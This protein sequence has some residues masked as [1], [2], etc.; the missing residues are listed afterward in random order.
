[1][2][3]RELR[4]EA[5]RPGA[6]RLRL[7]AVGMVLLICAIAA[8]PGR[9]QG[10]EVFARLQ[11]LLLTMIWMIVPVTTADCISRERREG[12]LPLLALTNLSPFAIVVAKVASRIV[13]T[14]GWFLAAIPMLLI[15]VMMGGVGA[16]EIFLA[17]VMDGSSIL[18]ALSAGM[19]A[20]VLARR[21]GTVVFLAAVIAFVLAVIF[22]MLLGGNGIPYAVGHLTS[23]WSLVLGKTSIVSVMWGSLCLT[24]FVFAGALGFCAWAVARMMNPEANAGQGRARSLIARGGSP[25]ERRSRHLQP[26]PEDAPM[27]WMF[28]QRP[29]PRN[30]KWVLM[31]SGMLMVLLAWGGGGVAGFLLLMLGLPVSL[32]FCAASSFNRERENGVLELLLVSPMSPRKLVDARLYSLMLDHL[33]LAGLLLVLLGCLFL[34]EQSGFIGWV[35]YLLWLLV[36]CWFIASLGVQEALIRSSMLAALV[37]VVVKSL[38]V[39]FLLLVG[40]A[41]V[42]IFLGPFSLLAI[43][44]LLFFPPAYRNRAIRALEE[45]SYSRSL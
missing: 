11:N 26:V 14:F 1:M 23:Q 39:G 8:V 34:G 44:L 20:S 33:P 24:G 25:D 28:S 37:A 10:F 3:I 31:F 4:V 12:T 35:Y 32:A 17:M 18:M 30:L 41:I 40:L 9:S 5:R 45:R 7:G 21:L 2:I 38:L 13:A 36:Q 15:P 6:Y 16:Q 27:V 42:T 43:F 29:G 22:L 19:M